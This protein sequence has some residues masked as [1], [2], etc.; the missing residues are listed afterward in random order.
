MS[1]RRQ[2]GVVKELLFCK[3]KLLKKKVAKKNF[4][5][6][7]QAIQA[8]SCFLPTPV[9]RGKDTKRAT[10]AFGGAR[11]DCFVCFLSFSRFAVGGGRTLLFVCV[12]C[13]FSY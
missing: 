1:S 11:C 2:S 9:A 12:C 10:A 8:F 4:A 3:G 5:E 6:K 7:I 13:C